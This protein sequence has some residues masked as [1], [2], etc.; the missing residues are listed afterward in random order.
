[1][2]YTIRLSYC[3]THLPIR[4]LDLHFFAVLFYLQY[5]V[6]LSNIA[7]P[8][9]LYDCMLLGCVHSL[10][11]TNTCCATTLGLPVSCGRATLMPMMYARRRGMG[12]CTRGA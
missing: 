11:S 5:L 2:K 7:C 6:V 8:Y 3:S 1:M 10:L 4:L 12:F 9:T